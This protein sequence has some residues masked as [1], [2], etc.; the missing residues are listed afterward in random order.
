MPKAYQKM[1]FNIDIM[2]LLKSLKTN[3]YLFGQIPFR[4]LD[5]SPHREMTD[6]WIR[7]KDII[8]NLN[9]G[10]FSNFTDEHES[11]WYPAS[12]EVPEVKKVIFDVM[13][14]VY[15]ERLGGVLITKLPPGG[16]IYPHK[17]A[18]WHAEFYEKYF[19]PIQNAP[20]AIFGFDEGIIE[21]TPGKR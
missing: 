13:H 6:I 16:K 20:G 1:P 12:R 9:S 3:A 10:D 21:P 5:E 14:G 7:Y 4:G 11:V 15:G 19:I 8:P 18:G 17:D 2:P